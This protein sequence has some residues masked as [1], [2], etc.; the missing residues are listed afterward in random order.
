MIHGVVVTHGR[1]AAELVSVVE[2]ILGPGQGLTP[3]SNHGLGA[4]DLTA[5]VRAACTEAVAA[6]ARGLLLFVD[7]MAGS[8][9]VAC[10]IAA[11]AAPGAKVLSGVNLAMLL[12][13]CTWRDSLQTGELARRLVEKGREAIGILPVSSGDD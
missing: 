5:A 13:F 3:L 10:R 11:S 8:C 12:D 9:A 7:D 2:S 1:V 6:D 4:P